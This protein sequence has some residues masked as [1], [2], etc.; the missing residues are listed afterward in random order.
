M[1]IC[2]IILLYSGFTCF[3]ISTHTPTCI[4][5]VITKNSSTLPNIVI[6]KKSSDLQ[7]FLQIHSFEPSFEPSFLHDDDYNKHKNRLLSIIIPCVLGP[8]L[9]AFSGFL[10]FY[11]KKNMINI[12]IPNLESNKPN[13]PN[14]SNVSNVSNLESSEETTISVA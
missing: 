11:L 2:F 4:P 14:V 9:I 6:T 13:E 5:S 12:V 8:L 7:F 3:I 10:Y 1:F